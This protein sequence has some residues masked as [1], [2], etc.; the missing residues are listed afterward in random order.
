[1]K[2]FLT[3]FAMLCALLGFSPHASAYNQSV[4]VDTEWVGWT[5]VHIKTKHSGSSTWGHPSQQCTHVT[6]TIYKIE[7]QYDTP[8]GL[9]EVMFSSNGNTDD[10]S[11]SGSTNTNSGP[12][13]SNGADHY[14]YHYADSPGQVYKLWYNADGVNNG[15][16]ISSYSAPKTISS[17]ELWDAAN[18]DEKVKSMTAGADGVYTVTTDQITSTGGVGPGWWSLYYFF[19]VKYTDNTSKDFATIATGNAT[20]TAGTTYKAVV[21]GSQSGT[22]HGNYVNECPGKKITFT[23]TTD[24]NGNVATITPSFDGEVTGNSF[25]LGTTAPL[26]NGYWIQDGNWGKA[27]FTKVGDHWE[28]TFKAGIVDKNSEAIDTNFKGDIYFALRDSNNK[29]WHVDGAELNSPTTTYTKGSTTFNKDEM[30]TKVS[31]LTPGATYKMTLIQTASGVEFDIVQ[32]AADVMHVTKVELWNAGS[33]SHV[34]DLENEGGTQWGTFYR[35]ENA[36]TKYNLKVT[37]QNEDE[38]KTEVRYVAWADNDGYWL[39]STENETTSPYTGTNGSNCFLIRNINDYYIK[40]RLP[41]GGMNAE[42]LYISVKDKAYDPTPDIETVFWSLSDEDVLKSGDKAYFYMSALQNDNRLSPEWELKPQG[43]GTYALENFVVIPSAE[44]RIREVSK[45]LTGVL[46]Y[47]DYGWAGANESPYYIESVSGDFMLPANGTV[48]ADSK[49]SATF[50][51][52]GDKGRGFRWNIGYSMVRLVFNPSLAENNLTATIDFSHPSTLK[53][54]PKPG[55]PWIGLTASTLTAR[56][57]GRQTLQFASTLDSSHPEYQNAFT[58]AY[59]QFTADGKVYQYDRHV[60]DKYNNEP[61]YYVGNDTNGAKSDNRVTRSQPASGQVMSSTILPPRNAPQFKMATSNGIATPPADA[62]TFKWKKVVNDKQFEINGN[63]TKLGA[64]YAVYE[65]QNVELEGMFKIFSGYGARS[66]GDAANGL[67]LFNNWGLDASSGDAYAKEPITESYVGPLSGAGPIIK[68]KANGNEES[69]RVWGAVN[70]GSS[71]FGEED[72][73]AGKYFE[74]SNRQYVASLKLYYALDCDYESDLHWAGKNYDDDRN[75]SNNG[76]N[77]SWLDVDLTAVRPIISLDKIG[78]NTGLTKY[79]INKDQKE[80]TPKIKTFK[81]VLYKIGDDFKY[82]EETGVPSGEHSTIIERSFDVTADGLS[83]FP[84]RTYEREN[85]EKGTYIARIYEVVYDAKDV[86][87]INTWNYSYPITVFAVESGVIKGHQRVTDHNDLRYYHPILE[88]EP[89]LTEVINSLPSSAN[90]AKDIKAQVTVKNIGSKTVILTADEKPIPLKSEVATGYTGIC[91]EITQAYQKGDE[92]TA[93]KEGIAVIYYPT[94]YFADKD[95]AENFVLS[96]TRVN[97]MTTVTLHVD[98]EGAVNQPADDT[99]NIETY[100]PAGVIEGRLVA[101]QVTNGNVKDQYPDGFNAL[102]VAGTEEGDDYARIR[103]AD[104]DNSDAPC[105]IASVDADDV[106]VL[107]Q[108]AYVNGDE[109]TTLFAVDDLLDMRGNPDE[110]GTGMYSSKRLKIGGLPYK[111]DEVKDAAGETIKV[112]KD[113]DAT[114]RIVVSYTTGGF[115][116]VDTRK[117]ETVITY[118]AEELTSPRK[119][120]VDLKNKDDVRGDA[121]TGGK[122]A[123]DVT[124][125]TESF[126]ENYGGLITN[127][128]D[129]HVALQAVPKHEK[130]IGYDSFDKWYMDHGD[131]YDDAAATPNPHSPAHRRA[132]G[133]KDLT[134]TTTF[135]EPAEV[136][137][138]L[139]DGASKVTSASDFDNTSTVNNAWWNSA[140]KTA[141][142]FHVSDHIKGDFVR[143]GGTKWGKI[144][145]W[146]DKS[147][148]NKPSQHRAY[149]AGVMAGNDEAYKKMWNNGIIERENGVS[150]DIRDPKHGYYDMASH[151]A[152]VKD[153]NNKDKQ[154]RSAYYLGEMPLNANDVMALFGSQNNPKW[155]EYLGNYADLRAVVLPIHE[156]MS[157]KIAKAQF[158][159]YQASVTIAGDDTYTLTYPKD[160]PWNFGS[161]WKLRETLAFKQTSAAGLEGKSPAEAIFATANNHMIFKVNHV[162]HE[163]WFVPNGI[164]Q[165]SPKTYSL[166]EAFKD[167]ENPDGKKFDDCTTE[168]QK[169]DYIMSE[170]RMELDDY[171]PL[172]YDVRYTYPFLTSPDYVTAEDPTKDASSA[173]A[174]AP[175]RAPGVG[176]IYAALQTVKA[177]DIDPVA[178]RDTGRVP[179]FSNMTTSPEEVVPTAISDVNDDIRGN[180]FSIVY[181][182]AAGTVTVTAE[183]DRQL[184][185]AAVYDATGASLITGTSAD[186]ISDQII[187]LDVRNIARGAYVVSTNL[188]GAK[189]MK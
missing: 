165:G 82:D 184:K 57:G 88:I 48:A 36:D 53:Q 46:S 17:I 156:Q 115:D 126:V 54:A 114:F 8:T 42:W 84:E 94:G 74:L 38:T 65:I 34:A 146:T 108:I 153:E 171:C 76:R 90:P 154:V 50:T 11:N 176:A 25:V 79:S 177:A 13:Y 67:S 144:T 12:Y 78:V 3:F 123:T 164:P 125:I 92:I 189:F 110:A 64:R 93:E 26:V 127:I 186:R 80:G 100:M 147:S 152:S 97:A 169:D 72:N 162:N 51:M 60:S 24:T 132:I 174:E 116:P 87:V 33:N 89:S 178:A 158:S 170:I 9:A 113:Q 5:D 188:G 28:Y 117:K 105:G 121:T 69:D 103:F 19:R 95:D 130:L 96:G 143:E 14:Y 173:N 4:Y 98:V 111:T 185:D 23:L 161:T 77:F 27:E 6:G 56:S 149:W 140:A 167:Y 40:V 148:I 182:R 109:E 104:R 163:S 75:Y 35:V 31:G 62:M 83:Y 32:D 21:H 137:P 122:I 102:R 168:K 15:A 166:W 131:K 58:N 142:A 138:L 22:Q 91:Y 107:A 175:R 63:K 18:N 150:V 43:D 159:N 49:H 66:Y 155:E 134:G 145:G 118:K 181:N 129:A 112:R 124:A 20:L 55:M 136:H 16:Q 180:G 45:S 59:I 29:W 68:N 30:E 106:S 7:Y 141:P 172:A 85:L 157:E 39:K 120:L 44:F 99:K 1:M 73:D 101:D 71:D 2:K 70:W 183:G 133:H 41:E 151:F 160:E 61:I 37:Y 86:D 52:K 119:G 47:R 135:T 128:E 10:T 179:F 81:V 187:V 139:R